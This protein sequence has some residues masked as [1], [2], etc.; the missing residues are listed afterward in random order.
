MFAYN[1]S[2]W[3]VI[4]F[5]DRDNEGVTNGGVIVAGELGRSHDL[6]GPFSGHKRGEEIG[7]EN[8]VDA[9]SESSSPQINIVGVLYRCS[10]LYLKC[11]KLTMKPK[12]G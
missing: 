4:S 1:F 5:N 9:I 8:L 2:Y 3:I 10:T 11:L 7:G 6:V 12:R